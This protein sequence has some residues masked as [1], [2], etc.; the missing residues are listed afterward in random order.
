M[1]VERAAHILRDYHR[2]LRTEQ[3]LI[4]GLRTGLNSIRERVLAKI[5]QEVGHLRLIETATPSD[6]S[7]RTQQLAVEAGLCFY[8]KNFY[9]ILYTFIRLDVKMFNFIAGSSSG[10]IRKSTDGSYQQHDRRYG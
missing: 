1:S 5:A 6:D 3:E 4:D 9:F 10:S 2:G 8:Y 7:A